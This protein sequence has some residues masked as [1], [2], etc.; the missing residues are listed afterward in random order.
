[1]PKGKHAKERSMSY[2]EEPRS[3]LA[4]STP[5]QASSPISKGEISLV[6]THTLATLHHQVFATI[7]HSSS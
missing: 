5:S 7:L 1:M 3:A 2:P 6:V 4:A